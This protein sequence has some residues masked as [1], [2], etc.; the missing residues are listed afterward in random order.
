VRSFE[1]RLLLAF[2][3]YSL[4]I[5]FTTRFPPMSDLPTHLATAAILRDFD[6]SPL[7]DAFEVFGWAHSNRLFAF[8]AQL[9]PRFVP[10]AIVGKL[11]LAVWLLL[12]L[13]GRRYLATWRPEAAPWASLLCLVSFSN[14]FNT[15]YVSYLV[16]LP[17]G[18][19]AFSLPWAAQERP[20]WRALAFPAAL[21]VLALFAHVV[22][23]LSA[24]VGVAATCLAVRPSVR[25]WARRAVVLAP[26]TAF[27]LVVMLGSRSRSEASLALFRGGLSFG[28]RV[29]EK[30]VSFADVFVTFRVHEESIAFGV[31]LLAVFLLGVLGLASRRARPRRGAVLLGATFAVVFLLC[32][33]YLLGGERTDGRFVPPMLAAWLALL[34]DWRGARLVAVRCAL[35]VALVAPPL[36]WA[37]VHY[38]RIGAVLVRVHRAIEAVPRGQVLELAFAENPFADIERAAPLL[39]FNGYNIVDRGGLAPGALILHGQTQWHPVREAPTATEVAAAAGAETFVLIVGA[40][41]IRER[42]VPAERVFD[43]GESVVVREETARRLV[44]AI[45]P[46]SELRPGPVGGDRGRLPILGIERPGGP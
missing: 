20:P 27:S 35:L 28:R 17:L 6:A 1:D 7:R 3:A 8:A 15:G 18:V 12:P 45:R 41:P 46:S 33:T 24:A 2:T 36:L 42:V 5:L 23:F 38:A 44:G 26:A 30:A 29:Y 22:A 13:I 37:H 4:L 31:A 32:R 25:A 14:L 10:I 40:G 21:V 11:A 19:L 16:G 39:H 43:D 34:P 9:A